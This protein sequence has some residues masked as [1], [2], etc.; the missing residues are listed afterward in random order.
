[1]KHSSIIVLLLDNSWEGR[2]RGRGSRFWSVQK[3]EES[4]ARAWR[5]GE[6]SARGS[7]MSHR[8]RFS[9]SAQWTACAWA[10]P[11]SGTSFAGRRV[12][13]VCGLEAARCLRADI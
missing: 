13:Y 5:R 3:S 1:M 11:S 12:T 8:H 7:F 10:S 6:L 9:T 4:G 2:L